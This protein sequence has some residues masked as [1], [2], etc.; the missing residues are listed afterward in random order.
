MPNWCFT[1]ITFYGEFDDLIPFHKKVEEIIN[2]PSKVKNDFGS[3]WLGDFVHHFGLDEEVSHRGCVSHY[4]AEI[5]EKECIPNF[6]IQI[7]TAWAPMVEIWEKII[8]Q[9]YPKIKYVFISEE[10]GFSVYINTDTEQEFYI[11]R[12][13]VNVEYPGKYEGADTDVYCSTET[14]VLDIIK[15]IT[16]QDVES[17][18]DGEELIEKTA[19]MPENK[20]KDITFNV[21]EYDTEYDDE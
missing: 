1:N 20:D 17:I 19:D 16:G 8:E 13:R 15:T 4:D 11:T 2:T 5:G 12:Y 9:H 10:T 7:E 3:G 14:E 18:K 21:F 6:E